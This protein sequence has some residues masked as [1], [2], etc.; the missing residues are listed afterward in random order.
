MQCTRAR[1]RQAVDVTAPDRAEAAFEAR[2]A[3]PGRCARLESKAVLHA[4][5]FPPLKRK[6][7]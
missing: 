7:S 3:R 5:V 4:A 6:V 1:P 2:T